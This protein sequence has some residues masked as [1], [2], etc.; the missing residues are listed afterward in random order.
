VISSSVGLLIAGLAMLV[1]VGLYAFYQHQPLDPAAAARVS[2]RIDRIFPI[3]IV[4]QMP[5][6][7]TGVIIAGVFAAAIS[8]L[9]SV[10]AALAQTVVTGV[11]RPWREARQRNW[12][13]D[14]GLWILDS[15]ERRPV[16]FRDSAIANSQPPRSSP[17]PAVRSTIQNPRSK[18]VDADDAHYLRVSKVLVVVWGIAL[19]LMAQVC[20]LARQQYREILNLA[21]AMATYTG[22]AMLAA[23]MLALLRLNVDY[24]G[25]AW[26][27]PISV[28]TVFAVSWHQPWAKW[29]TL[30]ASAAMIVAWL[31]LEPLRRRGDI[32]RTTCIL[33]AVL[34]AS[35]LGVAHG[36]DASGAPVYFTVA[37]PWNVPI[38]FVVAFT[39]GYVLAQ[40]RRSPEDP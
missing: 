13:L 3:F 25:I 22:G 34:I 18:I 37:W 8:S 20:D 9:D 14:S 6:G 38:G 26:S 10:L 40:P 23:F 12:I 35:A 7:L 39:L 29:T 16:Q 2:E 36:R 4:T 21:L 32:A 28:L 19:C 5:V 31:A 24:R 17:P 30:I 33:L 1:G 11:Y 27:A 15:A